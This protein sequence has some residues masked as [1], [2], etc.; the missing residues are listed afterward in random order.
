MVAAKNANESIFMMRQIYLSTLDL[1]IHGAEP[2]TSEAEIQ[3]LVDDLRPVAA[4][5]PAIPPRDA[6]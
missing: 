5:L 3:A 2:P 6:R 4:S 1:S